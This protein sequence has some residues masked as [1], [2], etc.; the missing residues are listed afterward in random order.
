MGLGS[1]TAVSKVSRVSRTG[2]EVEPG[3][4][5]SEQKRRGVTWGK[6]WASVEIPVVKQGE[7]IAIRSALRGAGHLTAQQ[8]TTT[9]SLTPMHGF[10]NHAEL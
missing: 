8:P 1:A 7:R 2:A 3:L 5:W 9:L 10:V 6:R 4:S